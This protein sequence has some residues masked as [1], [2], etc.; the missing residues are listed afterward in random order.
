MTTTRDFLKPKNFKIKAKNI[1]F[2]SVEFMTD[3]EKTKIYKNFISFLNNHFKKTL[4][5]KNLYEHFYC[6]CDFIAHYDTNGFYGE[7]FET[8]AN[9]H[10]NVNGYS[11]PMNENSGNLNRS[12]SLSYG[13][14]FYAIYEELNGSR[15]G[16]GEFYDTLVYGGYADYADLNEAIRDVFTEYL[17]IWR[18]EIKKAIKAYN[19]FL[20]DEQVQKLNEEKEKTLLQIKELNSKATDIELELADKKT[21]YELKLRDDFKGGQ[22]DLFDFMEAL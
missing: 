10:F 11:N 7:Y 14:Q 12:S 4:F 13:E 8:A 19:E 3:L 22:T 9:Y 15:N 6:H 18:E 5:K 1:S 16:L 17:E 2:E 21:S 20:K